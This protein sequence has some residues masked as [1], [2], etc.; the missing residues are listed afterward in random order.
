MHELIPEMKKTRCIS[1]KFQICCDLSTKLPS[2]KPAND[3][4]PGYIISSY[5]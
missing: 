4:E 1:C 2:H 3:N 5:Y